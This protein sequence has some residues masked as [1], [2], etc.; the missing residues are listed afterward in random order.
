MLAFDYM[1]RDML[2]ALIVGIG[3]IFSTRRLTRS[4][5]ITIGKLR[6]RSLNLDVYLDVYRR[7][8][9]VHI[10]AQGLG[11]LEIA[12]MVSCN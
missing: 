11:V 5:R 10:S 2:T 1:Q 7:A 6:A 9:A 8:Q 12:E 4:E 3:A